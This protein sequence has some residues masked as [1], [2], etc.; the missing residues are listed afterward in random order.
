MQPVLPLFLYLT[1]MKLVQIAK[2]FWS[3]ETTPSKST[4][5][6]V[7]FKFRFTKQ[8]LIISSWFLNIHMTTDNMCKQ[9]RNDN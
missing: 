1:G 8:K 6:E 7:N 4:N 9:S 2:T 3:M 5:Q